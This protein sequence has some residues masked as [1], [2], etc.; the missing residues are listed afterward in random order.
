MIAESRDVILLSKMVGM[1]TGR[2]TS[3]RVILHKNSIKYSRVGE[4]QVGSVRNRK[5]EIIFEL[6]KL[7]FPACAKANYFFLRLA[8][9]NVFSRNLGSKLFF[10]ASS[11]ALELNGHS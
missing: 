10:T 6:H 9:A 1:V 11:A 7:F 8:G 2:E 3:I 5:Q 4:F